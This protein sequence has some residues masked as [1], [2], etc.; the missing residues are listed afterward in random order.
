MLYILESSRQGVSNFRVMEKA[1]KLMTLFMKGTG[2]SCVLALI[3]YYA[4]MSNDFVAATLYVVLG[5]ALAMVCTGFFV[6]VYH[7]VEY[8]KELNAQNERQMSNA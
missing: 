5:F 1:F 2:Y 8:R 7:W 4:G 3:A 6:G